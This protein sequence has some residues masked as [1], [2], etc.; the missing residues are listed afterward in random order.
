MYI[1]LFL[2]NLFYYNSLIILIILSLKT[3][4]LYIAKLKGITIKAFCYFL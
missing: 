2:A 3:N 4:N 1:Y